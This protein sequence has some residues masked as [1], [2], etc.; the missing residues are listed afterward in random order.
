MKGVKPVLAAWPPK[1]RAIGFPSFAAGIF[2]VTFLVIALATQSFFLALLIPPILGVAGA[3]FLVGFPEIQRKDGK[4]LIEPKY[5]PYLFFVLAPLFALILYPILGIALTQ[6]GLPLKWLAIVCIVLALA[7]AITAAYLLVGIP[8]LYAAARKQY[9][10]L[11]PE[12]RPYLFFP[13]TVVFFLLF[14]LVL[15][16]LTTQALGALSGGGDPTALLNIQVMVL[17]PVCLVAAG[18]LAWL[19]VG[20]PPVLT[21]PA[22]HL[23]KV[24]GKHR[25]RVFLATTVLL[26]IPLFLVIGAI[27]TSLSPLPSPVVLP[28]AFVLG[29]AVAFGIAVV[30]WG[31]PRRWRQYEDYKP[32]ID[33]RLRTPLFV[34]LA[35]LAGIVV[36]VGFGLANLDLFWGM[37][38]GLLVAVTVA[39][40]LLGLHRPILARRGEA[41]LV[42][43]LPDGLKP[44]IL[45]PTW[46]VVSGLLFAVMTYALPSGLVPINAIVSLLAGLALAFFLLEQPLLK[47]MRAER[48]AERQKRKEWEARRKQR[49]AEAEAQGQPPEA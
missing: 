6:A 24:T 30:S 23:P 33:P 15:G 25:P 37:L 8:N 48:K 28:L 49:L 20:I 27:L 46:F 4:P 18:L 17:T 45:F 41:T 39:M 12:R 44:L 10:T 26:G 13:L 42:P 11:P 40:F 31:T 47:E 43:D 19:L 5:R 36:A 38:A 3:Y 29:F 1:K 16:V 22:H 35:L 21:K 34:G 32:G 7:I 2:L 14:Y 9:E